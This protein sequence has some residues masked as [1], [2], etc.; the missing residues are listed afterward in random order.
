MLLMRFFAVLSLALWMFGAASVQTMAQDG[1]ATGQTTED[2]ET[3]TDSG[4]GTTGDEDTSGNATG[5][6]TSEEPAEEPV[7]E[8]TEAP[9]PGTLTV[10]VFSCSTGGDAGTGA[11]F[12]EDG[13]A[14]DE[15]CEA[16]DATIVI[17]GG[18]A[19][20]VSGSADVT[21]DAG[22]H[23]V[24]DATTGAA[25]DVEVVSDATT[26]VSVV[27]YVAPKEEE[28][29]DDAVKTAEEATP[30]EGDGDAKAAAVGTTIRIIKHVCDPTV[31]TS[32][33]ADPAFTDEQKLLECPVITLPADAP[34]PDD[35]IRGEAAEFDF[36]LDDADDDGDTPLTLSTDGVPATDQF[37]EEDVPIDVD[38][39]DSVNTCFDNSG[40]DLAAVPGTTIAAVETPP[41][42]QQ[43][44]AV[45]VDAADP[46]A[47]A[48]L[49]DDPNT[50]TIEPGGDTEVTVHVYNFSFERLN[51]IVHNCDDTVEDISTFGDIPTFDEQLLACPA[52]TLDGD[53]GPDNV[54]T[55]GTSDFELQVTD[56]EGADQTGGTFD[57][58]V[59]CEDTLG[60][61]LDEGNADNLCLPGY[62]FDD[63]AQGNPVTIIETPDPDY[64]FGTAL[65]T[66]DSGDPTLTVEPNDWT[67]TFDTTDDGFVTVHIFNFLIPGD[68]NTGGNNTG[69][70]NTGGNN[71][72]GNNTGGD[73]VYDCS[74]FDYQE[75]AQDVLDEDPSDPNDL[76]PDGN[77]WACE[78]LPNYG[79]GSNNGEEGT[80]WVVAYTLYC[81]SSSEYVD[82]VAGAPGEDIDPYAYGDDTCIPDGN[83][84]QITTP[85]GND[86]DPVSMD[87]SGMTGQI[88][89]ESNGN[90][91]PYWLTDTF[92]GVY[93]EFDI[94]PDQTTEVVVLVWEYDGGDEEDYPEDDEEYY[95]DDAEEAITSGED[96][97]DTGTGATAASNPAMIALLG[98]GSCL[99]LLGGAYQLR[100]GNRW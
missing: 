84:I 93:G 7:E 31:L 28:G 24:A 70:N 35:V 32:E 60:V 18:E 99:L 36:T 81:L 94:A 74:D 27:G 92:S 21:L 61:D 3:P 25:L 2:G 55:D 33:F 30:E 67:V 58:A 91:G 88:P 26:T 72:G 10:Q 65:I 73:D 66:P 71:T 46:D 51:V 87:S 4:N 95:P 9:A 16:G 82:V 19:T 52:V 40:Y 90:A 1:N 37:C 22:V 34:A 14:P 8:P 89:L 75:D 50:F 11:I 76:D 54:A 47:A 78:D 13:F 100:R 12:P 57:D 6:D 41:A 20:D 64:D 38:G 63:V 59:A 79:D 29:D 56:A 77:G 49:G 5:D 17:D 80:G 97:P 98:F 44:G 43:L 62:V 45:V 85:E 96:L 86:M 83:E 23:N 42:H 48:T 68:D 53:T 15:S 39:D 69:G